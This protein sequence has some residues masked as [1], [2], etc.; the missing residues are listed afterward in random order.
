MSDTT[1]TKNIVVKFELSD[2]VD[3]DKLHEA[4]CKAIHE[5]DYILLQEL[6]DDVADI[7]ISE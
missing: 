3:G 7:E 6:A 1:G 4:L 5:Q 2:T